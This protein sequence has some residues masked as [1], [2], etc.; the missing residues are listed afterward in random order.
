MDGSVG[1]GGWWIDWYGCDRLIMK[2][3]TTTT[4]G[5]TQH[6]RKRPYAPADVEGAEEDGVGADH[7]ADHHAVRVLDHALRI[8]VNERM[9]GMERQLAAH[10]VFMCSCE[11]RPTQQTHEPTRTTQQNNQKQRVPR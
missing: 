10:C 5:C 1:I 4:P 8:Y 7:G 11:R 3:C 2:A 6:K 9:G